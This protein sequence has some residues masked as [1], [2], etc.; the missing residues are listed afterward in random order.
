MQDFATQLRGQAFVLGG[1][2]RVE[3]QATPYHP[4][5][6]ALRSVLDDGGQDRGDGE[7]GLSSPSRLL[8]FSSPIWLAEASRLLPE[9][10]EIAPDLPQPLPAGPEEA[11]TRLF[12]ALCQLVLELTRG[13]H[14]VLLC[15][16]DLHWADNAT[17]DLLAYL[18][19]R[20][21][22]RPLLIIGAYRSEEAETVA[23]LRHSLARIGGLTELRL[24]G[25]DIESVL[26]LLRHLI[27]PIPGDET[28]ARRLQAAT[29]GNPF[30]LLET[31]RALLETHQPWTEL[32]HLEDLPLS[33]AIRQALEAR[34][35]RLSPQARQ[36][37]E[38]GAILGTSFDFD[39]VRLT[40]GRGEME[41]LDGLDELVAR[42]LLVEERSSYRFQHDLTRRAVEAGLS[43]VRYQLLHRRAGRA[44][45][46]VRPEATATLAYHFDEGGEEAKALRY[47]I[48]AAREAADLSAWQEAERH[49]T[50]ALALLHRLDP[51]CSTPDCLA[52]RGQILADR[53]HLRFLQGR[54]AE[55][56]ADLATMAAL[57]EESG[58][59]GLRLQALIHKAR[60]LNL[61]GRYEEAIATAKEGLSLAE[62]MG[63][64]SARSSLLAQLGFAHYF[65]GEYQA[66][67]EPLQAALALEPADPAARGEVL[68]VLSY[69]YYLIA[70]YE[71]S[72]DYRR[73]ALSIRSK[74]GLLARVAED[75]T[76]MG[77][78]HTRL[79]RLPEAERYLTRALALAREIGSQ[80][81]E[82]YALNNLGNLH[83]LRGDYPAALACYTES[84]ALQRATG[85][86]RGEASALGNSG[87]VYLAL[88][89]YITAESLLRQSLAIQEEIGYKSG[90]AEGLAHLAQALAG[91][92]RWEEALTAARH[93]L[94]I[95]RAIGDRYGQVTALNA[96][97]GLHL[98]RHEPLQAIRWAQ[99]ATRL[100]GETAL[101]HGR[102]LGLTL[103]GLAYQMTGDLKGALGCTTQAVA[104]LRE[105]GHI[106]GPEELVYL[107]HARVLAALGLRR[108]ACQALRQARAEMR[109][110]AACISD[111]AQRQRY[112]RTWRTRAL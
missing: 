32:I 35:S 109:A 52:L 9:L 46:Q 66:A 93:S 22:N 80:P 69:A 70:D 2:G 45:E 100:A 91:Q 74:L 108:E 20:L 58:D 23:G 79:N 68:S 25:L 30:Y 89:D 94:N 73:Q 64:A 75:L 82:S 61:D 83:Y 112:L 103:L 97:A 5:V 85:S 14:P 34:I 11:R 51:D 24:T 81:A 101:I 18:A 98:D 53:A 63:D 99:E 95:A 86:R 6:E 67:M 78:L 12:E 59:D 16:D 38:A 48:Q 15:L 10:R 17:L 105:Q 28:L 55:R 72:L 33:D 110:K 19:R 90:L 37:L 4:M 43:P 71:R 107:G 31:V 77:I 40:A 7:N 57:A 76:D 62:S 42:Q 84:L 56:D 111:P 102:I 41:T 39:L 50:R 13:P 87:M 106:E 26:Q 65:R 60:Y 29:G 8:R 36:I 92:K 49:Q 1:A 3:A 54:L 104:L 27:G 88:G 47:Y 21:R 96:L 44:L